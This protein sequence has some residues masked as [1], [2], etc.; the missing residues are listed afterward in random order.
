MPMN[1]KKKLKDNPVTTGAG[2]LVAFLAALRV[3]GVL[4]P[5]AQPVIDSLIGLLVAL[6]LLG[7]RDGGDDGK[8]H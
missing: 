2:L 7:A 4:G 8:G 5:E 3:Q 1:L 6:G